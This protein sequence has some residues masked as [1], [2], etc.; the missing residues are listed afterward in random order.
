MINRILIK[1]SAADILVSETLKFKKLETGGVLSGYYEKDFLIIDSVSGPG[2]N[3]HHQVD[4]FIIDKEYMDLYLD[5]QYRDSDGQNIY[6]GEW[7]THPQE[8][9]APSEQDLVS[10]AERTIEWKHGAIAFMIIGFVGFELERLPSQSI[11]IAFHPG[12]Q[13]FYKIPIK[14]ER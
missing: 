7:H 5:Q 11:A 14:Y 2:P 6:I 4:E 13:A 10:I 9:P 3:A 12:K 8:A 1:K